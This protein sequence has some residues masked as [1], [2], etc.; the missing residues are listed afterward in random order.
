MAPDLLSYPDSFLNPLLKVIVLVLFIIAVYLFY[1]CRLIYGGKLRLIAT[2]L[3][4]GGVAGILAWIFR[5]EGDFY[6]QWKWAESIFSLVLAIITLVIAYIIR[7]KFKN[8]LILFG[9]DQ[10][11]EEK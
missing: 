8:A 10:R 5:I 7:M 9:I 3:L 11:G 4:F 6:S 2:L 1:R